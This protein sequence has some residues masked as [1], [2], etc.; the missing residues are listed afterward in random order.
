VAVHPV[1]VDRPV[2]TAIVRRLFGSSG[3]SDPRRRCREAFP[4]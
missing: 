4:A 1:H 2:M 3:S